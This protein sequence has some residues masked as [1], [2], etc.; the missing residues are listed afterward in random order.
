MYLGGHNA[1]LH[2]S[3][4][5]HHVCVLHF[6]SARVYSHTVHTYNSAGKPVLC[7]VIRTEQKHY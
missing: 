1:M 6:T 7:V 3:D 4:S 5:L 2:C